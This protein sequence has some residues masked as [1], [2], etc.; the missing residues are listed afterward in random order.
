MAK[1]NGKNVLL[2]IVAIVAISHWRQI[3]RL[4]AEMDLG[5]F[6]E[7]FCQTLHS[8]PPQGKNAIVLAV[9][10]LLYISIYQLILFRRKSKK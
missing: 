6:W 1:I 3:K 2:A 9:L 8:L 10:A 7:A 5:Q 4:I